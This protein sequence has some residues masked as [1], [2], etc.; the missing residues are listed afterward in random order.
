VAVALTLIG[1][2][3]FASPHT[4][5][6]ARDP[7]VDT[8][9]I[10]IGQLNPLTGPASGAGLYQQAGAE[11]AVGEI[12]AHG[13]INGRPLQ[14]VVVDDQQTP[15]GGMT[16]FWWLTKAG[17]VAAIIG[18]GYS[19]EVQA[20]TPLI[21]QRRIPVIIGGTAPITT[22]EGDP[23]VFRTR[24][25][26]NYEAKV[27]ASYAVNTLH[28]TK[29]ALL[30]S[31]DTSSLGII[32]VVR[33]ELAALGATPVT[34][35]AFAPLAIDM[36]VQLQ[37]VKA[38]GATALITYSAF[39]QDYLVMGR[40]M[41]EKGM[42]LTWLGNPVMATPPVRKAGALFDG[43]YTVTD[44]VRDQSPEAV[45]F[46]RLSQA[47]L[48]LPGDFASAS[49]YDG[50]NILAMVMP[51]VGTDPQAIRQGVL[52]VQ[53]YHGAEGIYNFDSNGD[54]LHQDTL[55]QNVQGKLR[56]IKAFTF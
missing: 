33:T 20:L 39:P 40:Q 52:A 43:T 36:T 11:L 27:L 17:K 6:L 34:D 50:V 29:I 3:L 22:H 21:E 16:A 28:L 14:L 8:S 37:A 48:Q 45:A 12:N 35:Q 56:I 9:P 24:P 32:T 7:V 54:G 26:S 13:G 46:D 55:V 25:N 47:T 38:S 15:T 41:K 4:H 19:K 1:I 53:G 30:H 10:Y 2:S 18:P 49:V 23:W 5:G 42:H 51:K 31:T 44:Y